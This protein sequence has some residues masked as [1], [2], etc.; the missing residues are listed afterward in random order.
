MRI[1]S[2]VKKD[3]AI[4]WQKTAVDDEGDA[5]FAEPILIKCRWDLVQTDI[6]TEDVVEMEIPSNNV[7]PDRVLAIGSYLMLGGQ[8]DLENL[9]S[10]QRENPKLLR[11][12]RSVKSQSTIF[13][14]GWRQTDVT[15]GMKS[16]HMV[17][18]CQV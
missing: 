1:H 11:E 14:L 13:E 12:A 8:E 15:P 17:I 18:D 10:E 9:T 3:T 16:D 4:Y 6:Q 5:V 2:L 7:Y